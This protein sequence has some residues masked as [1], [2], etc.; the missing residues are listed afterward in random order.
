MFLLNDL[1]ICPTFLSIT[2][3]WL[4]INQT[5]PFLN[6][7]NDRFYS[8]PR[9]TRKGGGVGTYV[10]ENQSHWSRENL[11]KF[12]EI[13]ESSFFELKINTVNIICGT[14][15][16]PPSSNAQTIT[17][18]I[19]IL[20]NLLNLVK[21]ENKLIYIMGDFNF[22][23]LNSDRNT[24][25]FVDEMFFNGNYPLISK[26]TRISTSMILIDNIWTNNLK[27]SISCAVLTDLVSDHFAIIQCTELT[28]KN[29]NQTF[30]L[31]RDINL[32]TITKF[33][34]KLNEINWGFVFAELDQDYAFS[35]F[36]ETLN[37]IFIN[38]IPM[39]KVSKAVSNMSFDGELRRLKKLNRKAYFKFL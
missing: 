25:A 34:Q 36:F 26:P 17:E 9:K 7:P 29:A 1:S 33:R 27:F 23:L 11:N 32:D 3:T 15:Y 20:K 35:K 14:I 19:I 39:K 16:C 8:V 38:E 22:N 18:F 30:Q 21:K 4:S 2:E 24:D 10:Y 6:L 37:R 12:E 13:I 31:I 28:N 5:G